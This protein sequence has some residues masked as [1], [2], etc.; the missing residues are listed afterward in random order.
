MGWAAIVG[1]YRNNKPI[2]LVTVTEQLSQKKIIEEIGGVDYLSKLAG[3]VPTTANTG[4]YCDIVKSRALRRRGLEVSEKIK[5]ISDC[6][7][8]EEDE[9]Y[10]NEIERLVLKVRPKTEGNLKHVK[11]TRSD[12]LGYLLQKDDFIYTGFNNFDKWMGGIGRGWLYILAGRPSVGK[13]AKALQM[14]IGIAERNVGNVIIFSQEMTRNQLLNRM[15]S[16]ISAIPAN[17]IRRKELSVAE[18]G[19]I[20]AA[21]KKLE[22]LPIYI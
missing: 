2:D 1:L 11:E 16:P 5:V 19:K 21:Y 22:Q 6:N 10:L 12:Y 17:R 15:I 3:S 18:L 7:E 9:K 20:E 14:A 4:F 8:F 13:T